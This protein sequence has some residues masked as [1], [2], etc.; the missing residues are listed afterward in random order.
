MKI[1]KLPPPQL[2]H[3]PDPSRTMSNIITHTIS[4]ADTIA[5]TN[6]LPFGINYLAFVVTELGKIGSFT[7][8]G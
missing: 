3:R 5:K 8:K 6:I 7:G 1:S 2:V 4:V